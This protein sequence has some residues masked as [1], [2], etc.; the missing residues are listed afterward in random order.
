MSN[1]HFEPNGWSK[2]AQVIISQSG[3]QPAY[4]HLLRSFGDGYNI[5]LQASVTASSGVNP[6]P[7]VDGDVYNNW[8]SEKSDADTIEWLKLEFQVPI[9]IQ[10]IQ[11][12]P[13]YNEDIPEERCEFQIQLSNDPDF[14]TY[15][16]LGGQ[17]KKPFAYYRSFIAEMVP[18]AYNTWDLY[19]NTDFGYRYIRLSG[20]KLG[21]ADLRVYGVPQLKEGPTYLPPAKPIPIIPPLKK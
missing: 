10:K 5:A 21:F 4:G 18:I 13:V 3:L 11:L 12:V 20:K 9:N 15:Y 2:E 7:A 6:G 16:I 17:D 1:F 19:G 14:N 8:R